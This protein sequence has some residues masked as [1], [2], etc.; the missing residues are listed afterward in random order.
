MTAPSN[1]EEIDFALASYAAISNYKVPDLSRI[2]QSV[3]GEEFDQLSL[4]QQIAL[5]AKRLSSSIEDPAEYA[6][7][8]MVLGLLHRAISEHCARSFERPLGW[9]DP[10]MRY[11]SAEAMLGPYESTC[12]A[13]ASLDFLINEHGSPSKFSLMVKKLAAMGPIPCDAHGD[14]GKEV[15][16]QYPAVKTMILSTWRETCSTNE[17]DSCKDVFRIWKVQTPMSMAAV[18]TMIDLGMIDKTPEEPLRL[19]HN[20]LFVDTDASS[21]MFD[22]NRLTFSPQGQTY[23]LNQLKKNSL[24]EDV[25]QEVVNALKARIHA[26]KELKR[27]D[28]ISRKRCSQIEEVLASLEN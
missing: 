27:Y 18:E 4:R 22:I 16:D 25:R 21:R 6:D 3:N 1:Q 14:L 9:D 8:C 12:F 26:T 23:L 13:K 11:R 10:V 17:I 20:K 24:P 5:V 15:W 7:F 2:P 28:F 19:W